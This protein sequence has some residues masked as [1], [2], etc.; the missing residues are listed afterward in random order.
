MEAL[1]PLGPAAGR[2]FAADGEDRRS[3]G[4]L[5]GLF[6]VADFSG[7]ESVKLFDGG[8]ERGCGKGGIDFEHELEPSQM[9]SA[10]DGDHGAG[11]EREIVLEDGLDG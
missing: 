10:I 6:D 2:V 11:G 9:E 5:P 3:V 8:Q 4:G 1:G 7:G